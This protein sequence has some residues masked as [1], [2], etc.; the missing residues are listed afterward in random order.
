MIHRIISL[1]ILITFLFI[2]NGNSQNGWTKEKG[3]YYVQASLTNFSSNDF[4]GTEGTLFNA[5]SKFSSTSLG[6][7]G[8]YGIADRLTSTLSL[9]L[10]LQRFNTTESSFGLGSI[11]LGL[12]YR[13]L[14][15]FPLSLSADLSIPTGNGVQFVKTKEP[16]GLGIFEEINLPTTDGEFNLLTTLAASKSTSN[17]NTFFTL[18]G[19]VNFRTESFSHQLKVGGEIGHLFFG[20]LYIIGKLNVFNRIG[21]GK[22]NGVATFLYGEGT[23]Y[24]YLN[25]TAMY[26]LTERL[27]LIGSVSDISDLLVKRRNVYDGISFSLGVA[28]TN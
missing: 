4:Y 15:N 14:N 7:Y 19:A 16:N 24:T 9:P 1:P 11:E 22:D 6:I 13:L 27:N 3:K 26:K 21:D 28:Y 12:K 18:Y 23:S 10:F 20:K 17:G 2:Q 5:G 8:E 25:I